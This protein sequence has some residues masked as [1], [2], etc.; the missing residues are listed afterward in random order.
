MAAQALCEHPDD[1]QRFARALCRRLRWW[2]LGLPAGIGS[3]TLLFTNR[4]PFAL[5]TAFGM[6]AALALQRNRRLLTPALGVLSAISSPV[7]GLFVAMGGVAYAMSHRR[8][9]SRRG[10]RAWGVDANGRRIA[11]RDGVIL[12]AAAF[13]PPVLLSLAFWA[14]TWGAPGA[15]LSSPLTVVAMVILMQFPGT[16]WIAVLLS[17][18]GNPERG[19]QADDPSE[20]A[21]PQ[22]PPKL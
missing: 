4:L 5:G 22:K 15:F 13:L 1:P 17:W 9:G 7:A 19:D 12:A 6:A 14:A 2:L 11:A 10:A 18:D 20:P 3:A 8:G 16:R 21:R